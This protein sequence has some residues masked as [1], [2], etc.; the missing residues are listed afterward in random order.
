[1]I[2]IRISKILIRLTID[3]GGHTFKH[4]FNH[5][6]EVVVKTLLR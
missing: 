6:E 4:W 3:Y 2:K 5:S 1:M